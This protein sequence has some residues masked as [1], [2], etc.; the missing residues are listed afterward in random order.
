MKSLFNPVV[1]IMVIIPLFAL[2]KASNSQIQPV[3]RVELD[4]YLGQWFQTAY[5]PNTF[6]PKDCGITTAEYSLK[7]NGRIR[8]I[9]TCWGDTFSGE[10]RKQ[11]KGTAWAVDESNARLKVRFFWPFKADY[12]II[13]LDTAEY[14]HA[15]VSGPSMKYLW[16]LCREQSMDEGY[17]STLIQKLENMGFDTSKLVLTSKLKSSE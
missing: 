14:Y 17:Y 16:I 7:E 10:P 4:R 8:V 12:W 6:Q 9:N 2:A 13:D 15:V 3:E 1:I 11:A 5:Y